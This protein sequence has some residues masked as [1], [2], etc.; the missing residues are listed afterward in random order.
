MGK[1]KKGDKQSAKRVKVDY[2]DKAKVEGPEPE[3]KPKPFI[4]SISLRTMDGEML[5][6]F[7]M[8]TR[9]SMKSFVLST[10][11]MISWR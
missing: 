1:K 3:P 5:D 6:L 10:V 7:L 8:C 4:P 11:S 2:V 9:N